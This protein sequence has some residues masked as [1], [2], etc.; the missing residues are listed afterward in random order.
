MTIPPRLSANP[1]LYSSRL[2]TSPASASVMVAGVEFSMTARYA[3]S[4]A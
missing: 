3:S 2:D 4:A 1:A